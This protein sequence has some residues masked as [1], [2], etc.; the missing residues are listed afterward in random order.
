MSLRILG[1]GSGYPL[2]RVKGM[3]QGPAAG[4]SGASP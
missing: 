2:E 1:A 4:T 3:L